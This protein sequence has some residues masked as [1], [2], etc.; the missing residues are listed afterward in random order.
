MFSKSTHVEEEGVLLF[1]VVFFFLFVFEGWVL[2]V[3]KP[4]RR[5]WLEG[6]RGTFVSKKQRCDGVIMLLGCIML[7]RDLCQQCPQ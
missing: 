4:L 5:G 1:S 7:F 2:H 3:S 6:G